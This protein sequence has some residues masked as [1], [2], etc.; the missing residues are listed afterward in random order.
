MKLSNVGKFMHMKNTEGLFLN[1]TTVT[2]FVKEFKDL[3]TPLM[4]ILSIEYILLMV[5]LIHLQI[6]KWHMNMTLIILLVRM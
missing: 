1:T 3:R 5:L 6:L 4:V 2:T